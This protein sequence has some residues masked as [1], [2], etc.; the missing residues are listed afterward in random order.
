MAESDLPV[1]C[2]YRPVTDMPLPTHLAV[3]PPQRVSFYVRARVCAFMTDRETK[4]R[5]IDGEKLREEV[6]CVECT[7]G[8]PISIAS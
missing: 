7:T 8:P 3:R 4:E 2:G 5:A 1:R 6:S